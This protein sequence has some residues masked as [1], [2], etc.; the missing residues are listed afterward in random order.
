MNCPKCSDVCSCVAEPSP[1]PLI[2][3]AVGA[4]VTVESPALNHMAEAEANAEPWRDEL[5]QR[6]NRYR[7]RRKAPPPRYPSLKLPFDNIQYSTK[8]A[9]VETSPAPVFE[10]ASNH[11]LALDSSQPD[12]A[13][14][15]HLEITPESGSASAEASQ[16]SA[17]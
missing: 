10:A 12:A 4:E 8:P 3:E 9:A 7:E 13:L 17:A 11:A 14:A 6:L 2:A 16:A 5:A 15:P 1:N